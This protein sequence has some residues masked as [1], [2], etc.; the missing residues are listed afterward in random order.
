MVLIFPHLLLLLLVLVV[1]VLLLLGFEERSLQT[2]WGRDV[3][4]GLLWFWPWL[5]CLFITVFAEERCSGLIGNFL[6]K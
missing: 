5:Y 4:G 1:L 2:R 3:R 6:G